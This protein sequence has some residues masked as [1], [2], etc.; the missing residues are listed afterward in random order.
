MAEKMIAA[1]GHQLGNTKDHGRDKLMRITKLMAENQVSGTVIGSSL[2]I[3]GFG[4]VNMLGVQQM[5]QAQNEL[6]YQRIKVAPPPLA[7]FACCCL[8]CFILRPM[9]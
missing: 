4:D 6:I 1:W 7:L 2:K 3:L 8:A 9:H 5:N